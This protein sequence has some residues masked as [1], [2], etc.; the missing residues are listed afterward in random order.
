MCAGMC[1][2]CSLRHSDVTEASRQISDNSIR[3]FIDLQTNNRG[4]INLRITGPRSVRFTG[5]FVSHD[6]VIRWKHFPL[7]WPFLRGIHRSPVDS[8]HKGQWR[9]YLMIS[10]ICTWTNG[11][12]NN[13][14]AGDLRR[15]RAHYDITVMVMW[16]AFPCD[17]VNIR[18]CRLNMT[19]VTYTIIGFT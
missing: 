5:D 7:Y 3:H 4:N 1:N 13:R 18:F 9:G 15:H 16:K 11:Q 19:R 10:L 8:P 6:D 12:A 17:D 14:Y 2:G